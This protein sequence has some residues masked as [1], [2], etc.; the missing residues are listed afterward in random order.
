M[1]DQAARERF[2]MALDLFAL[3]EQMV[4]QK[5]RRTRPSAT[6]SEVDEALIRWLHT[7]SGADHGDATG[8]VVSWPRTAQKFPHDAT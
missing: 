1:N 7:R 3:S 2:E 6:Q 4:R 8:R 5:V